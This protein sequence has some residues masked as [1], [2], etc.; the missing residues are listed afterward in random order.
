MLVVKKLGDADRY[1]VSVDD[2]YDNKPPKSVNIN[3]HQVTE[4]YYYGCQHMMHDHNKHHPPYPHP[5]KH[6]DCFK[7]QCLWTRNLRNC[8]SSKT[9]K[10]PNCIC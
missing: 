7:R 10:Y 5:H 4:E 3:P 2:L 1:K 6:C 9:S 8:K